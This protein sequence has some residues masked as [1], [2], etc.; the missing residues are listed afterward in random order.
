MARKMRSDATLKTVAS[1][2]GVDE[3]LFRTE[4][5]RKKRN[6]TKLKTL[7]KEAEKKSK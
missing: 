4:S 3:S 6:D 5:G 7:R 2:L 1:K